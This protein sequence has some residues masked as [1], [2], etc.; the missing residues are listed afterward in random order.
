MMI[1]ATSCLLYEGFHVKSHN[2]DAESVPIRLLMG[3]IFGIIFIKTTKWI[4][5]GHEDVKLGGLDGTLA[6]INDN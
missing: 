1:A 2:D 4:L 3:V 5:D 6:R